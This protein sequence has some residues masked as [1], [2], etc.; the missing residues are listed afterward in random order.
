MNL[1]LENDSVADLMQRQLLTIRASDSIA[2]VA[3]LFD[4]HRFHAAPVVNKR[5]VCIGILT[6]S[7][8]VRFEAS[9]QSR[10]AQLQHGAKFDIARYDNEG[11]PAELYRMDQVGAQMT[12]GFQTVAAGVSLSEA[13]L[14]MSDRQLHHLLVL[15]GL[16]KPSGILS[17]MDI[18]GYLVQKIHKSD[19]RIEK[20]HG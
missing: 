17:T 11:M 10:Q 4:E 6:S 15:D 9:W 12:T 18:L 2:D 19:S 3:K 1:D 13:I 20:G 7:D 16:G 14:M 8:L 5:G